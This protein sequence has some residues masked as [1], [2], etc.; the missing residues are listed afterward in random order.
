MDEISRLLPSS[1]LAYGGWDFITEPRYA[2]SVEYIRRRGFWA[3]PF[4]TLPFVFHGGR[5]FR[6]FLGRHA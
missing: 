5:G 1:G 2:A 6:V 4:G 3:N